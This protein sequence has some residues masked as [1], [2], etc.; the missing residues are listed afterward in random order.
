[1]YIPIFLYFLLFRILRYTLQD[2]LGYLQNESASIKYF[3]L[4]IQEAMDFT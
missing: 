4:N 2:W 3:L 1:M